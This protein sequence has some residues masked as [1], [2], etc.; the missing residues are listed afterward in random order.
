VK[1]KPTDWKFTLQSIFNEVL[2][3][4][5]MNT[6]KPTKTTIPNATPS[7]KKQVHSKAKKVQAKLETPSKEPNQVERIEEEVKFIRRFVLL[8]KKEKTKEQI[9]SFIKQLQKA[10]IE[11]RIR[12]VSKY[13]KQIEFIQDNLLK[14]Y[15]SMKST[16]TL[17]ISAK[18]LPLLTEIGGSEKVRLSIN[19]MKR[20]VGIHG[21]NITKEK[22]KQLF[23]LI[24]DAIQKGKISKTDPYIKKINEVLASLKHF[25][26]V[27]KRNETLEVHEAVLNGLEGALSGIGCVECGTKK[28]CKK[29]S[30][31]GL[32]GSE[33][34]DEPIK[35][36]NTVMNSMDFS[37]LKFD[38]IGFMGK[39]K[40]L[41]G[42]PSE[43]FTAMVFGKPKMGKS[44][45]SID[46]A[47]YLARNH[48]KT[49]YVAKEE[50]LDKT[51]QLKIREKKVEHP[52]LFF[53]DYLIEDLTPYQYIFLDSVT[54][55]KLTP[56]DLR[57]LET[58]NPGK[59][60]IYV[61]QVNK[62]GSARGTNEFLHN[63][64]IV[65]EIPERGKAVQFGRFNQGGEMEIFE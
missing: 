37:E 15:N 12:K 45:F 5:G 59:S 55:L 14:F 11:R 50:M 9:L 34:K 39:W 13:A 24:V 1:G 6:P 51:L 16:G 32:S 63:V 52:E 57:A 19:Y 23:N 33:E 62:A 8:N 61:F 36:E 42:D 17:E 53:S 26:E 3:E 64:D 58:N 30:L 2:Q 22:A 38:T 35:T 29:L 43:G 44:Y 46:W 18:L 48:G 4:S 21:K 40:D 49:L 27:S 47:G 56:E 7:P 31:N 25:Y 28:K 54:S 60:F 41:I 20:F 10:I 65:V